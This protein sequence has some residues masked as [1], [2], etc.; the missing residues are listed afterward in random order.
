MENEEE[1]NVMN[2]YSKKYS[3]YLNPEVTFAQTAILKTAKKSLGSEK[4][5]FTYLV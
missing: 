3:Y 4:V 2:S 5:Q 1:L